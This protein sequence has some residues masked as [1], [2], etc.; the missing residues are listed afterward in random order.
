[1][2]RRVFVTV[3]K[4]DIKDGE[5]GNCTD[6]ALGKA[7]RRVFPDTKIWYKNNILVVGKNYCANYGNSFANLPERAYLASRQFDKTRKIE[8][9]RFNFRVE[10]K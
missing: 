8:P 6:C 4:A 9:F 5:R 1:M 2:K 10:T 7:I 3:T